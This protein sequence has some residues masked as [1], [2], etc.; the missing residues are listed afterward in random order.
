M[1]FGAA[2]VYTV[3]VPGS[4]WKSWLRNL[5]AK[6]AELKGDSAEILFNAGL[7][8][9]KA[10]QQEAAIEYYTRAVKLRPD[11]AEAHL[12]L[13]VALQGEGKEAEAVE[14]F[15]KALE[16]KPDLAKGYF[17]LRPARPSAHV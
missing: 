12:N 7:L 13:G 11:F 15:E 9:Q 6:L 4:K 17:T 10:E 2:R 16:L 5:Y 14:C 8:E 1:V 3:A